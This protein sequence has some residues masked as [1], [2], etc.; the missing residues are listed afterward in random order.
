MLI[1]IIELHCT[2]RARKTQPL[3]TLWGSLQ[4]L[5]ALECSEEEEEEQEVEEVVKGRRQMGKLEISILP[6][7]R[8]REGWIRLWTE[9]LD[10]EL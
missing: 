3:R 4:L 8:P 6:S 10:L 7:G 5:P 2:D 1:P 9:V